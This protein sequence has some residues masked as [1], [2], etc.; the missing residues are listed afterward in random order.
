[1]KGLDSLETKVIG[2]VIN[3]YQKQ[4][5]WLQV[6]I[7]EGKMMHVRFKDHAFFLHRMQARARPKSKRLQSLK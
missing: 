3:V 6:D 7:G 2:T 4:G 5:C 1:M